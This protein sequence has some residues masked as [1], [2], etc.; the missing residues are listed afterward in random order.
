MTHRTAALAAL[1]HYY[2]DRQ[3][4][5][6]EARARGVGVV[7]LVGHVLPVELV[8]AAGRY[9]LY[10]T[11]GPVDSTPVADEWMEAQFDA[12]LRSL[13]DRLARGLYGSLD[14]LFVSRTYR[15][16]YFYLKELWR[17]GL[18]PEL[19]PLHLVDFMQADSEATRAYSIQRFEA[20]AEALGRLNGEPLSDARIREAMALVNER[21]AAL[22]QLDDA[23]HAG[24]LSGVT[25]LR[26]IGGSYFMHPRDA[27]A[28]LHA[29]IAELPPAP[30]LADRPRLVVLSSED[31]VHPRLHEAL[32]GG[33]ALVV[34]EDDVWG[35]RSA[36]PDLPLDGDWREALLDK[37]RHHVPTREVFP[38]Q[39]RLGW[40]LAEAGRP[41][42][43]GVVLYLPPSDRIVGWDYPW[44]RDQLDDMGQRLLLL[45]DDVL[46]PS[47]RERVIAAAAAFVA[48]GDGR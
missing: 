19:A 20:A 47:G 28:A 15:D 12:E 31:L 18:A 44:L 3:V 34:G 9:P 16:V 4:A 30:Q 40:L 5:A 46:T 37:Y 10:L 22:R 38:R 1:E 41:N 24:R 13:F 11:A 2:A 35:A 26:A 29:L 17:Q 6:D 48:S 32:E 27:A 43:D 45:R 42:V 7:G 14:L 39:N 33:G 23:R 25:A 8:L 36:T 21:S